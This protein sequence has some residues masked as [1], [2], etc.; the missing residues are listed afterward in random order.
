MTLEQ[1]RIFIAVAEREHVTRAAQ[2][3][4]LTQSAVSAAVRALEGQHGVELFDR[5]GR[6]I[7][8]TEAGRLFVTEARGVLARAEAAELTLA[9]LSGLERGNL[10]IY[11]SQ[12]IASYWLP[13]RLVRFR[14]AHPGIV[15]HVAMSN[16]AG[17]ARAVQVG[18]AELG[19]VEGQ[20][21]QPDLLQQTVDRDQLVI[22]VG[23]EPNLPR[24]PEPTAQTLAQ[25]TWIVR[26]DGSGTRSEFMEAMGRLGLSPEQLTI[27]LEL[28]SN[29]AVRAAVEDGAGAAMVSELVA[30]PGLETG[31]L[32]KLPFPPT[33]RAFSVLRH[34]KRYL[35]KAARAMLD[36]LS[37]KSKPSKPKP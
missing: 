5:I 10:H 6:G 26:E 34:D 29:E 13:Q 21:G 14:A 12:T 30:R 19:L 9:E 37:A 32:K 31:R 16:T 15:T 3:L 1:L 22:V 28:P 23:A 8:L 33:T 7:A 25:L 17:V 11:A 36:L 2:A 18:D 35:S 24:K 27:G 20:V 4:N